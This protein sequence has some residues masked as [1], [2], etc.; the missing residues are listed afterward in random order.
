[1]TFSVLACLTIAG[2]ALANR[3]AG[4]STSFFN[5]CPTRDQP[6]P[7]NENASAKS[8]LVPTPATSVAV[9][10]YYGLNSWPPGVKH[11]SRHGRPSPWAG[12]LAMSDL[13]VKAR[14]VMRLAEL[15]DGLKPVPAGKV[16]HC[17][18]DD[19]SEILAI[20]DYADAPEDPVR[21]SLRGCQWATNGFAGQTYW[22]SGPL[23]H[24]LLSLTRLR[25]IG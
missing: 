13:V 18:F 12:K 11:R 3:H 21:V 15:F 5:P 14:R 10:R 6:P 7:Q 22:T 1:V 25:R 16:F 23:M 9:C 4:F 19:G 20:F 17:P 8:N 2:I 24:E